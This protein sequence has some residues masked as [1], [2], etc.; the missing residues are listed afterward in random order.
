[1]P[2]RTRAFALYGLGLVGARTGSNAVR[3]S[4][5]DELSAELSR[6]DGPTRDLK[7]AAI[8]ALGLTPV[9]W[10]A[11]AAFEG[12]S[13]ASSS[14]SA[15]VRF[16]QNY[17]R[18]ESNEPLVRAHVP[19]ALA[20]LLTHERPLPAEGLALRESLVRDCTQKIG[21]HTHEREE[22]RQSCILALGQLA[23]LDLDPADAQARSELR[24]MG[25]HGQLQERAF[26]MIAAPQNR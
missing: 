4:I 22:V 19:G 18:N 24:R 20:R 12:Q 1:V 8:V 13:G 17:F 16:L 25:E 26:A 11:S 5:V 14:R 7:V 23:D 10:S 21:E 2:I 15:Q 3:S 6:S 9:D